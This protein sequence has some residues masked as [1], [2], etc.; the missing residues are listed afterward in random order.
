M[1]I[2]T[3]ITPCT[4]VNVSR[5]KEALVR[6]ILEQSLTQSVRRFDPL[7][8]GPELP[9]E[10]HLEFSCP[11]F[12][13]VL[14]NFVASF[15]LVLSRS[16]SELLVVTTSQHISKVSEEVHRPPRSWY[17]SANAQRTFSIFGCLNAFH[18]QLVS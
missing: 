4:L 10:K 18:P 2:I 13:S 12:A 8:R 14:T 1:D 17:P 3:N 16:E 9:G 6:N 15:P 11:G 7:H 5:T